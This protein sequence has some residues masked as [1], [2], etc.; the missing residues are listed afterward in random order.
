MQLKWHK[1]KYFNITVNHISIFHLSLNSRDHFIL[2][3][4]IRIT[5]AQ[6]CSWEAWYTVHYTWNLLIIFF[7]F[8]INHSMK[9]AESLFCA[10][11]TFFFFKIEIVCLNWNELNDLGGAD[12]G[13]VGWCIN[14][15]PR[16]RFGWWWWGR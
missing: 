15:N 5:S 14:W 12:T 16:T 1:K 11:G 6:L 2:F 9:K 4:S 10:S 13:T 8:L 7:C 3:Q